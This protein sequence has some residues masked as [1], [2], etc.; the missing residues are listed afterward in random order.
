MKNKKNKTKLKKLIA[1]CIVLQL[2]KSPTEVLAYESS[3]K[4]KSSVSSL[5][6]KNEADLFESAT[7]RKSN[8][9]QVESIESI[10]NKIMNLEVFNMY[11]S[12]NFTINHKNLELKLGEKQILSLLKINGNK[13][14][15]VNDDLKFFVKVRQPQYAVYSQDEISTILPIK[16]SNN[17][18]IELINHPESNQEIEVFIYYKGFLHGCKVKLL[19]ADD[20]KEY[21]NQAEIEKQLDK[22]VEDMQNLSDV[23]KVLKAHDWVVNNIYY[24]KGP[25]DQT[26]YSGI[27][28]KRTVC[29]GY[30]KTFQAIMNKLNIPSYIIIGDI[31]STNERHAWNLVELEGEWYHVDTTWD[32]KNTSEPS[33]EYF[34]IHDDDFKI[35][36]S[37]YNPKKNKMGQK[38]RYYLHSK[39]GMVAH[40]LEELT[41]ILK[42]QYNKSD[43]SY[44]IFEVIS[45]ENISNQDIRKKLMEITGGIVISSDSSKYRG[46]IY[47]RYIVNN[48]PDVDNDKAVNIEKITPLKDVKSKITPIE[49]TLNQNIDLDKGNIYIKHAKV[50]DLKKKDNNT[51]ILYLQDLEFIKGNIEIDIMKRGYQFNINNKTV[52]VELNKSKTPNAIFTP[53]G[54]LE[55]ILKNVSSRMQ[56]RKGINEWE[57]ISSD[58]FKIGELGTVEIYIRDLGDEFTEKSDIQKLKID[59]MKDP[60]NIK[61]ID[62]TIFGVDTSME[63]RNVKNTNWKDCTGRKIENLPTGTYEVRVKSIKN[64][65][66][67]NPIQLEVINNNPIKKEEIIE[68]KELTTI[69]DEKE[70]HKSENEIVSPQGTTEKNVEKEVQNLENQKIEDSNEKNPSEKQNG[71]V[72]IDDD[73]KYF[74]NGSMVKSRWIWVKLENS[75]TSVWKYFNKEG[76]SIDQFYKEKGR[77]WLSQKGPKDNYLKGWWTNPENGQKYYFRTSSGSR[78]EKWQFIDGAWRYF[79]TS[80]SM[81]TGWQYINKSWYLF[82]ENGAN[83]RNT[84][85]WVNIGNKSVWKYFDKDG[86]S[87]D[88]FYKEN[89]K[90]WLSQKGPNSDYLKGWWTNPTNG[91]KYYFRT[92][93]G[94]RVTGIQYIEGK[95]YFFRNSGSLAT[96]R[97]FVN[98]VWMNF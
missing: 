43:F 69:K 91:A 5:Y 76:N 10:K 97:Q 45:S 1:L 59:M 63:Y 68:E 38:Y 60:F 21:K 16:I 52:S 46:Y 34:L 96:G 65:L 53:T 35:S 26:L 39:K 19:S 94:T 48:I 50:K 25:N 92:S 70:N 87:I 81:V 93:S 33:Y 74:E 11:E 57:N 55:G 13:K 24:E 4:N 62:G 22:I 66:P 64:K 88:Q 14:E 84:W 36:R 95:R 31:D 27:V 15:S 32:D 71:W 44:Q 20:E 37:Y 8:S 78:V 17:G 89:G 29:T 79:R 85:K 61:V 3:L 23:E 51:Y 73:Y 2:L 82:D 12:D 28:E 54:N 67:S 98:G 9:N 83:I 42:R 86:K 90:V 77:V 49:I 58:N 47:N 18:E 56:Y 72:K 41:D 7:S 40:N 30:A 80:G 75:N 6:S